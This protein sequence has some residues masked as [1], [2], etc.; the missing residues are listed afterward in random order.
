MAS[1]ASVAAIVPAGAELAMPMT[2]SWA[3]PIASGSS[4]DA[5]AGAGAAP[6][7]TGA[8]RYVTL[9]SGGVPLAEGFPRHATGPA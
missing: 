1:A 7:E 4:R 5:M 3:T 2:V 9:V 6:G 8:G